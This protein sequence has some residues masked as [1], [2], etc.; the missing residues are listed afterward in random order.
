MRIWLLIVVLGTP[1]PAAAIERCGSLARWADAASRPR[2]TFDQQP[3]SEPKLRSPFG[4]QAYVTTSKHFAF[5]AG[6]C[7]GP[8][9]P[10]A[11]A[12]ALAT[13]ERAYDQ[14][15]LDGYPH[16]G[17][18][19]IFFLNVYLGNSGQGAPTID[20][21]LLGYVDT[22]PLGVPFIVLHPQSFDDYAT[23]PDGDTDADATLVHE[24]FHTVQLATGGS[25]GLTWGWFFEAT[26]TWMETQ[27]LP[28]LPGA[29]FFG[30]AYLFGGDLAL[31]TLADLDEP[32]RLKRLHPY[33]AQLFV[34]YLADQ[35]GSPELIR[36]VWLDARAGER[37]LEVID[38][39]LRRHARSLPGLFGDF[40]AHAATLDLPRAAAIRERLDYEATQDATAAWI[41]P[42]RARASLT[43]MSFRPQSFA[44]NVIQLVP[45][46]FTEHLVV[47]EDR[48][49]QGDDTFEVRVVRQRGESRTYL[50]V[51]IEQARGELEI[52]DVDATE[53]IFV[54]IAMARDI[55]GNAR[56][57]Y[58]ARFDPVPLPPDGCAM[59][60]G[61]G[62]SWFSLLLLLAALGAVKR[63]ALL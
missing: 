49:G 46:A 2:Y 62:A 25:F 55:Q 37:P 1:L 13:L 38:K 21:Q 56:F 5:R 39:T 48:S 15:A 61:P 41:R 32:D 34:R 20:D 52:T 36:D 33:G 17:G 22:E 43:G 28:A 10:V 9:D 57:N 31:A 16:P 11:V 60:E 26:A 50:R 29:E 45:S 30:A 35:V 54:T 12:R 14:F 6:D 47:F 58:D 44:F 24:L 4:E 40:A 42:L 18:S 19:P 53:S 51:P 59:G 23:T 63:R 7:C 3:G 27:L 8:P